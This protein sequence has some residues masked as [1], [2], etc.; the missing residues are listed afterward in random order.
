M[1]CFVPFHYIS[2]STKHLRDK[3]SWFSQSLVEPWMFCHKLSDT[4]HKAAR[5]KDFFDATTNVYYANIHKVV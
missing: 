5:D 1:T 3:N 4:N 2:Y